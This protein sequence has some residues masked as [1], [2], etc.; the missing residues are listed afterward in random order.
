MF[1]STNSKIRITAYEESLGIYTVKPDYMEI[2]TATLEESEVLEHLDK[3]T[4]LVRLG[5]NTLYNL[6]LTNPTY[7]DLL[8]EN[9]QVFKQELKTWILAELEFDYSASEHD[10]KLSAWLYFNC[11][12]LG[13]DVVYNKKGET[14][15]EA[16]DLGKEI[17][18][19]Y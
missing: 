18:V 12:A 2:Y 14:V 1:A 19:L 10:A 8:Q 15:R 3:L 11:V 6:V 13:I 16:E 4:T 5:Y 9:E 17:V 7:K